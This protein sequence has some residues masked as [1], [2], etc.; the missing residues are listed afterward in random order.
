MTR[1]EAYEAAFTY[2]LLTGGSMT[3]CVRS[4]SRNASVGGVKHSSHRYGAGF[5]IQ[6][7]TPANTFD[8]IDI[9]LA[10]ETAGRLGLKLIREA[11]HDHVQPADW[12]AG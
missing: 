5:D 3:S 4:A 2:C 7:G 1:G 8:P 6:Y 9:G 10:I 12:K 11:D